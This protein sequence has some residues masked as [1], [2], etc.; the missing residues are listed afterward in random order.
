MISRIFDVLH[1]MLI[2]FP[3]W[4]PFF[5]K[6]FVNK[7]TLLIILAVYVAIPIHW[8]FFDNQCIVT[9]LTKKMGGHQDTKSK[10]SF[11]EKYLKWLYEPLLRLIGMEWNSENIGYGAL[12]TAVVNIS[13]VWYL[14]WKRI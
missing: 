14:L 1:L 2:F 5:T 11:S 6:K 9:Y 10:S 13:V 12:I 7:K 8:Y 3:L 4:L